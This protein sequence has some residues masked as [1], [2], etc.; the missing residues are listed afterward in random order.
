MGTIGSWDA[1]GN[2]E[3][4]IAIP[5]TIR[6]TTRNQSN[7]HPKA[8][9][10]QPPVP[11]MH[12]SKPESHLWG[13]YRACDDECRERFEGCGP[14]LWLKRHDEWMEWLGEDGRALY[15]FLQMA[16]DSEVKV[17]GLRI[18]Y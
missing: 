4:Y 7:R 10:D 8:G 14:N 18:D 2:G 5:I 11:V 6:R 13:R 1:G 17:T 9:L 16:Y 3:G 12:H 15:F